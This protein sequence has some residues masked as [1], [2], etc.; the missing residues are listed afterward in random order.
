MALEAL[1]ISF[2]TLEASKIESEALLGYM[3]ASGVYWRASLASLD[4]RK[5]R[6]QLPHSQVVCL[7]VHT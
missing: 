1:P 4:D 7:E 6:L 5:G 2:Y 3:F